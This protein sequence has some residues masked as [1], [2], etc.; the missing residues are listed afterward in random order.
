MRR[1]ADASLFVAGIKAADSPLLRLLRLAFPPVS[2]I[3]KLFL[4]MAAADA[5]DCATEKSVEGKTRIVNISI[6]GSAGGQ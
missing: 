5:P 6:S 1:Q 3:F 4:N 2:S